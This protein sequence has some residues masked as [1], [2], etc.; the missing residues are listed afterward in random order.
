[1]GETTGS[2]SSAGL[3]LEAQT[4]TLPSLTIEDALELGQ[5]VSDLGRE[6]ALPIATEVRIG[7]WTIFHAS[8]PGS[9]PE[10]D[11]WM[12]RKARV[13]LATGHSTIFERVLAEEKGI[14][15]YATTGLAED[16]YAIHGGGIALNVIDK[17][18]VGVLLVSGLPQVQDHLLGVEAIAEF[19]ARKGE[20]A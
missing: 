11:S 7:E 4:L 12:N 14:D 1:M 8:L 13:V 10:N 3:M 9:K 20:L 16:L 18:F 15:W 19:L 17:G 6:R 5:I 2:F